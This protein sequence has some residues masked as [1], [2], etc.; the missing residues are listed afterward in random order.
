MNELNYPQTTKWVIA[1]NGIDIYIGS[2]V[3]PYNC[4]ATGQ[5][6][7]D[8]FDSKEEANTAFPSVSAYFS[9]NLE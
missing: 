5:P 9:F 8:I 7:M 4:F 2:I 3:Y 6:F 1:H